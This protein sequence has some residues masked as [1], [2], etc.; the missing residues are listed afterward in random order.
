LP[1][2]IRCSRSTV[3]AQNEEL[4]SPKKIFHKSTTKIKTY[5]KED[6]IDW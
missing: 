1:P 4:V 3:S 2:Q 6:E 5:R